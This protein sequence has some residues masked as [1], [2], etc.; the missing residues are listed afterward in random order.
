MKTRK[1]S[2]RASRIPP[3]EFLNPS[4]YAS[5]VERFARGGWRIDPAGE[6]FKC[7]IM[8]VDDTRNYSFSDRVRELSIE[9]GFGSLDDANR[10]IA[11]YA[12]YYN[13]IVYLLESVEAN[14]DQESAVNHLKALAGAIVDSLDGNHSGLAAV[15]SNTIM[16]MG[17]TIMRRNG[18]DPDTEKITVELLTKRLDSLHA[19]WFNFL[20]FTHE[21]LVNPGV[22][23]DDLAAAALQVILFAVM[24]NAERKASLAPP[25]VNN[26][27]PKKTSGKKPPQPH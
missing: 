27:S 10:F 23:R 15:L 16:L 11:V 14:E 20:M 19:E 24:L 4:G 22:S 5:F 1:T 17:D 8:V 7:V 25:P 3:V 21:P 13:A 12:D 2:R 26:K 18:I 6:F 9:I